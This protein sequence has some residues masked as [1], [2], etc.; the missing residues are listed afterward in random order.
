MAQPTNCQSLTAGYFLD[1]WIH[2]SV[3]KIVDYFIQQ[4]SE[5]F[6]LN[7]VKAVLVKLWKF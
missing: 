5:V 6:Q 1:A 4:A 3:K 2:Y 7:Q